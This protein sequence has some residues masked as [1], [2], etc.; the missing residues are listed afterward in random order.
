MK[1]PETTINL[2]D[3]KFLNKK[4]V[5]KNFKKNFDC[6]IDIE[7][8]KQ[9]IIVKTSL[10]FGFAVPYSNNT[11]KMKIYSFLFYISD[12]FDFSFSLYFD[13]YNDL[14]F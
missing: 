4:M 2:Y 9:T 14:I 7:I 6:D 1:T 3:Q 11:Q 10:P 13:S 5:I 12:C 8:Y